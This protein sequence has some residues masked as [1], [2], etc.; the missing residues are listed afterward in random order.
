MAI[1]DHPN[2]PGGQAS[3]LMKW[4]GFVKLRDDAVSP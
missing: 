2:E 3:Q 4:P 1:G